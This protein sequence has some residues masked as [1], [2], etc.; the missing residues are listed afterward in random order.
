MDRLRQTTL[1]LAMMG[2]VVGA[3]VEFKSLNSRWFAL[4]GMPLSTFIEPYSV[5]AMTKSLSEG[6]LIE[7]KLDLFL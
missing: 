2:V 1:V 4:Y 7:I 5:A 3:S 6:F